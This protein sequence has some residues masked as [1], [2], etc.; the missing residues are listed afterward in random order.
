MKSSYLTAR[1]VPADLIAALEAEKLR[2]G[3]SLN[4]TVID[5]L[6]TSLGIEHGRSNGLR[7][8]AGTWSEEEHQQ[9]MATLKSFDVMDDEPGNEPVLPRYRLIQPLQAGRPAN[10]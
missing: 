9:M 8:L 1:N 6:R 7:R 3:T 2:R 5:V 10:R 4:Q